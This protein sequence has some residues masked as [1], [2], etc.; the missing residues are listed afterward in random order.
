M[1]RLLSLFSS[2]WEAIFILRGFLWRDTCR[3]FVP[4]GVSSLP[5]LP[6]D[7]S[8]LNAFFSVVSV[9]SSFF[10]RFHRSRQRLVK[11]AVRAGVIRKYT[12]YSTRYLYLLDFIT[13]V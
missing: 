1:S 3:S 4:F 6:T 12:L 13:L 8:V 7:E 5:F 2:R 11:P 9:L 10:I